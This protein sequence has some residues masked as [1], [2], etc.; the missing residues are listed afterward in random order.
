M[1]SFMQQSTV[2]PALRRRHAQ[3]SSH[4]YHV[5]KFYGAL[6][7]QHFIWRYLASLIEAVRRY[8]NCYL[9]LKR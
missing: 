6:H 7:G 4:L 3:F 1:I 2:R 9:L 8:C 5:G